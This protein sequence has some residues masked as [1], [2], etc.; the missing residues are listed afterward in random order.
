MLMRTDPFRDVDRLAQQVLG[1]MARPAVMPLDAWREDDR[2]I[3]EFDL[4]GVEVDSIELDVERN[5]L[6]VRAERPE[7][8]R[9]QE[10]VSTERPRGVFT[11]RLFLGDTL[12]TD[13]IEAHYR[14][15]V[16]RVTIPVA[17][18]A[19]PRKIT[20]IDAERNGQAAIA[21]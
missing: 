1:T 14:N 18:K 19:R 8:D 11:R 4:P 6:T 17:E 7:V 9:D 12:D 15:G 20:V 3:A 13:R 2:F 21:S 10:F 16:L 5:V